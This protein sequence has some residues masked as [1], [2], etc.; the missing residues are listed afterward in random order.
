MDMAQ[1]DCVISMDCDLQHPPEVVNE[2]IAKW[3]EGYDVVYSDEGK[4]TKTC[5]V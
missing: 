2:L 5:L 4:W 3:E 1:G